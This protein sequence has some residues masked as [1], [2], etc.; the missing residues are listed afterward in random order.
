MK[1]LKKLFR[2]PNHEKIIVIVLLSMFLAITICTQWMADYSY[3]QAE[4]KTAVHVTIAGAVDRPGFYTLSEGETIKDLLDKSGANRTANFR[5]IRLNSQLISGRHYQVPSC[6]MIEV[7]VEGELSNPGRFIIPKGSHV[8][9]LVE[10]LRMN[11]S[12][13]VTKEFLRKKLKNKQVV[14]IPKKR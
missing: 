4:R 14:V 2:L 6:K 8:S 5:K 12:A 3:S 7:K 1:S 10:E 13:E 9:D 11:E